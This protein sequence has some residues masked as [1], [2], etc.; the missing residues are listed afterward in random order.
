VQWEGIL[1]YLNIKVILALGRAC[2][3]QH[4]GIGLQP[5]A[6]RPDEACMASLRKYGY[7]IKPEAQA[8]L[9]SL[10]IE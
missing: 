5:A 10:G 2:A 9:R 6:Q 3:Q 4:H 1:K 7:M 8:Y